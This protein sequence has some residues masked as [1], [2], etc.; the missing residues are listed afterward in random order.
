M[1]LQPDDVVLV[2]LP[3]GDGEPAVRGSSRGHFCAEC[4]RELWRAPGPPVVALARPED[5]PVP[6]GAEPTVLL[7]AECAY[8]HLAATEPTG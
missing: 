8:H 5:G 4:S 2:C 1:I 3:V 6:W 7:C